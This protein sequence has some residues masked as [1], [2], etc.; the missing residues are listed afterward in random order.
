MLVVQQTSSTFWD[1][2]GLLNGR[3]TQPRVQYYPDRRRDASFLRPFVI[4]AATEG[5]YDRRGGFWRVG[6]Q[7]RVWEEA[8]RIV[9]IPLVICGSYRLVVRRIEEAVALR[10]M[11]NWYG[12]PPPTGCDRRARRRGRR[13]RLERRGAGQ[14]A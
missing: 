14:V 1:I 10:T 2:L 13:P 7:R 11:L 3:A 12:I 9:R 6:W 8:G 5:M 4:Q